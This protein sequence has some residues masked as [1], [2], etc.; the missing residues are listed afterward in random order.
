MVMPST[1]STDMQY[2]K[3]W[4]LEQ[5]EQTRSVRV[6]FLI[7]LR[8]VAMASMPRCTWPEVSSTL[9]TVSPS[10]VRRK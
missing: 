7:R 6:V 4:L 10:T 1:F 5:S 9:R 3:E 2:V 8:W